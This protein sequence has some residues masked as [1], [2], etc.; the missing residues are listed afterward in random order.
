MHEKGEG[1]PQDKQQAIYWSKKAAEQM[2]DPWAVHVY[3][4]S[5][6]IRLALHKE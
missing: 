4:Q 2:D 5:I 3:I 6:S 1:V